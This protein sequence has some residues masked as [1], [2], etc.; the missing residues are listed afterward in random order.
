MVIGS[1]VGPYQVVGK[2]G[3]GGMGQVYR[4]IAPP[5]RKFHASVV[6]D[7]TTAPVTIWMNWTAGVGR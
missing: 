7:G 1:T 5:A 3:E 6:T 2:L 4:S